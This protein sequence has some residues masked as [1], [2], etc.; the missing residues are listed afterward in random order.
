MP[1]IDIFKQAE[2]SQFQMALDFG[3]KRLQASG[4]GAVPRKAEPIT[5]KDEEILWR[6][7]ILGDSTPQSLFDTVLYMN[8]L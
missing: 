3:M 4:I 1:E 6:K 8:G 7:R 5:F 2:F